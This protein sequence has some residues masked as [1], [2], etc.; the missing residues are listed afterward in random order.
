MNGIS[1]SYLFTKVTNILLVTQK[2]SLKNVQCILGNVIRRCIKIEKI[3]LTKKN[4]DT[5]SCKNYVA[6]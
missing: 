4:A 1:E 3:C 6:H 2:K 5:G